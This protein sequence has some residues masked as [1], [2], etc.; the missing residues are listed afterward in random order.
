MIEGFRIMRR[1]SWDRVKREKRFTFWGS[2][3]DREGDRQF[4]GIRMEKRWGYEEKCFRVVRMWSELT[5]CGE[6]GSIEG[7]KRELNWYP[8]RRHV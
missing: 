7:F 4:H 6:V 8:E 1:V 3:R 5:E 2:D